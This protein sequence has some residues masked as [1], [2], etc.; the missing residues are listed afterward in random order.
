MTDPFGAALVEALPALGRYARKLTRN[1]DIVNDLVQDTAI[2]ALE[3]RAQFHGGLAEGEKHYVEAYLLTT[4]RRLWIDGM[5]HAGIAEKGD[6][7]YADIQE[8]AT[9]NEDTEVR[10]IVRD[11]SRAMDVLPAPEK[12][13]LYQVALNGGSYEEHARALGM[14]K[15]ALQR[16]LNRGREQ[17]RQRLYA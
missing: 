16:H 1:A 6:R 15:I 4:M 12:A 5:K 13:A 3:N 8:A 7:F 9:T 11:V 17:L 2:R 10:V 14:P